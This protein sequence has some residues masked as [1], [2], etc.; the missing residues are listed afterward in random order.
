MTLTRVSTGITV[1]EIAEACGIPDRTARRWIARGSMPY[2]ARVTWRVVRYGDLGAVSPSW[3][4]WRIVRDKLYSPENWDFR[5]GEVLTLPLQARMI[6]K[7]RRQLRTP[8]PVDLPL[9]YP[10]LKRESEGA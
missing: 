9:E 5:P 4:G 7:L 6:H 2:T 10:G 8:G 1:T 3:R